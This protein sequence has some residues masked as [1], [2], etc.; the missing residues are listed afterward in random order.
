MTSNG[1]SFVLISIKKKLINNDLLKSY[2]ARIISCNVIYYILFQDTI[3]KSFPSKVLTWK[4]AYNGL[5][6][7][8]CTIVVFVLQM[9]VFTHY[10]IFSWQ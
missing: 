9:F 6:V 5:R 3:V 1:G 8:F 7:V 2:N 4:F 10:C